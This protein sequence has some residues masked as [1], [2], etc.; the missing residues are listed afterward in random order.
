MKF[1]KSISIIISITF[2][3]FF[4]LETFFYFGRMYL[5]KNSVGFLV[6]FNK[7]ANNHLKDKCS[8]MRTHPVINYTHFHEFE[9]DVLG[10]SKYDDYFIW[11]EKKNNIKNKE[12]IFILTSGGS[13]TDGFYQHVSEGYTWPYYL[14]KICEKKYNCQVINGGTGGYST[15]QELI[16]LIT[17][18]HLI[19]KI[20]YI[21]SLNGINDIRTSRRTSGK[22]F[23]LHPYLSKVQYTMLQ[24]Q[25]WIRQDKIVIDIF[26]N[27]LSLLKYHKYHETNLNKTTLIDKKKVDSNQKKKLLEDIE[28]YSIIWEKNLNLMDKTSKVLNSNFISFLQPTMGLSYVEVNQNKISK[29]I[30]MLNKFIDSN[31]HYETNL[32]YKVIRDKCVKIDF[33]IDISEIAPP[34]DNLFSD[35]RHHNSKGNKIIAEKIFKEI[36]KL[37]N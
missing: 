6:N 11:Y 34:G 19:P 37:E 22:I 20:D 18:N 26:P 32:F 27:I 31:L 3:I 9:C 15:T 10:A 14:Q 17:Y 25:I 29:D 28:N 36:E 12:P 23:N 8:V 21:V 16:K 2:L 4:L 1:F 7:S 13:T 24:E 35:P 5:D 30:E 33:C